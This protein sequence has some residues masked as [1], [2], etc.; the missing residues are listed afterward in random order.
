[1]LEVLD[2]HLAPKKLA[3][4]GSELSLGNFAATIQRQATQQMRRRRRKHEEEIMHGFR[5]SLEVSGSGAIGSRLGLSCQHV[6]FT[7]NLR[8][9]HRPS[10]LKFLA[11]IAA[12]VVV[13]VAAAVAAAAAA[14]IESCER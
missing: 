8:H 3:K 5:S 10:G 9:P 13:V 4:S 6:L 2:G 12:A 1:M 11:L 7:K 14:A